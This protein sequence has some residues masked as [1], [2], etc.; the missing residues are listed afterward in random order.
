MRTLG[1]FLL[2]SAGLVLRADETR[3]PIRLPVVPRATQTA[4]EHGWVAQQDPL[5]LPDG[6]GVTTS[7]PVGGATTDHADS[8]V[9]GFSVDVADTSSELA[10]DPPS[11]PSASDSDHP[12]ESSIEWLTERLDAQEKEIAALREQIEVQNDLGGPIVT[13]GDGCDTTTEARLVPLVYEH[14]LVESICDEP[15]DAPSHRS[16]NY[17]ADYDEGFV[18]RPFDPA[19][20]P[21]ELKTKAWIQFRHH[22]FDRDV[23]SWTDNAGITRPVPNRNDF[24]IERAR[25]TFSGFALDKRSTYFLQLDGDT[26]G[27]HTVDFFDYWWAWKF[28]DR[29]QVQVGKRKVPAGRQWLLGA[30]R[31]RFVDRPVANDFFRPDR[32]TGLFARGKLGEIGRYEAMVG[33]GY[34]TANVPNRLTDNRFAY[35]WTNYFDP[36]GDFGKTLTDFECSKP[37]V[38]FGHSFVY[39]QQSRAAFGIP[40][41]EADF[42]RLTDGTRLTE[43]GALA[44]GVRVDRFKLY[45][46]GVD[47]AWKAHG[48]S[49]NTEAF[50]RWIEDISGDGPLPTTDLFQRGFY[51][52]GG[53]FLLPRKLDFNLRY[54][55]VSGLFGNFSEYAMGFNWF[56]MNT[57]KMKISFDVT[58]LDGSPLNNTA[59][60]V[61]VGD[62]GTLFRTQFQ[63]E[64]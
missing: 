35:A 34:Q 25:L 62:D 22:G 52:E 61:L 17:Y 15:A 47:F 48:W 32:T 59:I 19:R 24:D 56:P 55:Q 1:I 40:I 45:L 30:R 14:Q 27:F 2:L 21:F 57:R 9:D 64:F 7:D 39:S 16:L 18:I 42:L 11:A 13:D 33:A 8:S 54:S 28:G 3:R 12:S 36:F 53:F 31:T 23:D 46:Y 20:H 50:L 5:A 58:S 6:G 37:L 10:L 60:D 26:D 41:N 38:R 63:A 4:A 51:A 29:L 44:P 43:R 49:F